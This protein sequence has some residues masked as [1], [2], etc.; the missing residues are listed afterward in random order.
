MGLFTEIFTLVRKNKNINSKKRSD[1]IFYKIVDSFEKG[2]Y[3][4]QCIN[5]NAIF[6]SNISDIVFDLDILYGLHPIQACYIGIEY[7]KYIKNHKPLK[8]DTKVQS[9]KINQY[10]VHRYGKYIISYQNRQGKINFCNT[11]TNQESL[12]DPRDIALSPELIDEFDS[13]QAFYIG[14][15]AGFKINNPGNRIDKIQSTVKPILR[16]IK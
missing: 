7:A 15:Y 3:A 14:L 9:Y 5:T 12:M 1:Y 13:A 16:I 10:S 2:E 4:L 8:N 11:L 6:H